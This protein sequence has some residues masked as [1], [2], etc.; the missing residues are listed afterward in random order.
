MYLN[1]RYLIS[2]EAAAKI[3]VFPHPVFLYLFSTLWDE[4]IVKLFQQCWASLSPLYLAIFLADFTLQPPLHF[5][6]D[7]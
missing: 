2:L 4:D 7:V 5:L 3:S 6:S 1:Y